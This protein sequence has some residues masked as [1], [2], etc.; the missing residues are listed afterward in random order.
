MTAPTLVGYTTTSTSSTGANTITGT[1]PVEATAGRILLAFV[2]LD[3]SNQGINPVEGGWNRVFGLA[4]AVNT[5]AL[6]WRRVVDGDPATYTFNGT[7]NQRMSLGLIALSGA[8]GGTPVNGSATTSYTSATTS[9]VCPAVTTTV[10]DCLLLRMASFTALVNATPP[11]EVTEYYDYAANSLGNWV[12]YDTAAAAAGAQP[13]RT[14]NNGSSTGHAITVAIQPEPATPGQR[15]VSAAGAYAPLLLTGERHVSA[16]GAYVP[17]LVA[18]ERRVSAAGAY[19]VMGPLSPRGVAPSTG[20]RGNSPPASPSRPASSPPPSPSPQG[21]TGGGAAAATSG[22]GM[23]RTAG[24]DNSPYQPQVPQSSGRIGYVQYRAFVGPRLDHADAPTFWDWTALEAE[25][26]FSPSSETTLAASFE[27]GEDGTIT[28]TNA[29]SFPATGWIW[30][31]PGATGETWGRV[32]YSAKTGNVLTVEEHDTVDGEYSGLHTSGSPVLFWYPLESVLDSPALFEQISE[33]FAA[34]LW[35]ATVPGNLF[36]LGILRSDHIVLL[37]V[38]RY[39]AGAWDSWRNWFWG[40]LEGSN[41][42]DDQNRVA[43][44]EANVVSSAGVLTTTK[45]PAIKIGLRNLALSGSATASSTLTVA[46]SEIGNGEFTGSDPDLSPAQ[47]LDNKLSTLW[48][49][50]GYIGEDNP[51]DLP[52]HIREKI[53]ITQVFIS[54]TPGNPGTRWIEI[55]AIEAVT[56]NHTIIAGWDYVLPIPIA[57]EAGDRL[58]VV[59]NPAAFSAYFPDAEGEIFDAATVALHNANNQKYLIEMD[60]ATGTFTLEVL[61]ADTANIAHNASAADVQA[62]LVAL[63]GVGPDS[64]RVTGSPGEWLVTFIN[65]LGGVNGPGM[66][67]NFTGLTGGTPA[68]AET[69][70]GGAEF[71]MPESGVEIFNYLPRSGAVLRLFFPPAGQGQSNMAWGNAQAMTTW[72]PEWDGPALAAPGS[73]ETMRTIFDGGGSPAESKDYWEVGRVATPGYSILAE[74]F[75]WVLVETQGMNLRLGEDITDTSPDTDDVLNIENQAGDASTDGLDPSGYLQIGAEQIEYTKDAQGVAVVV[76]RGANGTT[77]SSHTAGQVVYA[78]DHNDNTTEAYRVTSLDLLRASGVPVLETF[79]VYRSSQDNVRTPD[80]ASY[81]TDWDLVADVSGHSGATWGHDLEAAVTYAPR[82]KYLLVEI[83]KM[84]GSVPYR[85]HVNQIKIL[86]DGE[87]FASSGS[88]WLE[89]A[90]VAEAVAGLAALAGLPAAAVLDLGGTPTLDDIT[91]EPGG[92]WQ[93]ITDLADMTRCRI[94]LG[95]DNRLTVGV[96][97]FWGI[98]GLP[99]EVFDWGRGEIGTVQW[100]RPAGRGVGQVVLEWRTPDGVTTGEVQYPES[101]Q[102]FGME[103]RLGPLVYADAAAAL[104]GAQKFYQ[105]RRR[106]YSLTAELAFEA[107]AVKPGQVGGITWDFDGRETDRR[108]IVT[109]IAHS[110]EGNAWVH[111]AGLEQISREDER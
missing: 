105:Q 81:L 95:R 54:P 8:A 91:T 66:T 44:W 85:A 93:T 64:V 77:P 88:T 10:A 39:A 52:D 98:S 87:G 61:A 42:R 62:A 73:G 55:T 90:T 47:V 56:G 69:Q 12:G 17:I 79:K 23:A 16:A 32:G 33:N 104:A 31:G 3:T 99:G 72:Q 63:G 48:I 71:P 67:A 35:T 65:D 38:R 37:Q 9:F 25:A 109:Q 108:Y 94:T 14:L 15:R 106:R 26:A 102:P 107:H 97:P 51:I 80:Q 60:G 41:I 46:D 19:V 13:T 53:G 82:V 24:G 75:E 18:G 50:A 40:W 11:A 70:T 27:A 100:N 29:D 7:A 21:T 34:T 110:L 2:L 1:P 28:L 5:C 89:S 68:I 20:R 103:V 84:G 6:F 78:L 74:D 4:N 30:I 49:S 86:A 22:G 57:L 45:A 96:D 101:R 83:Y 76:S 36:P 59:E 111:V 58:L 43:D 92:T